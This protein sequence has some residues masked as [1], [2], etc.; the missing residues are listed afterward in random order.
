MTD[1][2]PR[3]VAV[4]DIHGCSSALAALVEAIRPTPEDTIVALGDFLDFGLDSRAVLDQLIAL[5]KR[6]RLIPLLGNHKEMA[7][8]ARSDPEAVETWLGCG[9]Q[10]TLDSY[11]SGGGLGM[12]PPG[13]WR[14]LEGCR[15]YF[16]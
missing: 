2:A 7:L 11:G 6:C 16:E 15:D 3:L 9:G 14:F 13:H 5:E 10:A 4:G 1:A 8:A 12:I